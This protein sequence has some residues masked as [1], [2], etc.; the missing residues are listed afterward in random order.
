MR[1]KSTCLLFLL[2]LLLR[3]ARAQSVA[4][5]FQHAFG[6]G[7]YTVVGADPTQGH[8]TTIP[9]VLVPITL[10]FDAKKHAGKSFIMDAA[11]DVSPVLRSPIFSK[12]AFPLGGATQY[13]DAMLRAT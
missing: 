6:Q 12:F 4:P 7:S 13:A 3:S 5:T 1:L 9:T 2:A 10:S 11:P 8:I